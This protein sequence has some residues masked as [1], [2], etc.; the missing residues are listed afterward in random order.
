MLHW[1]A[2]Q[3]IQAAIRAGDLDDLPGAHQPLPPDSLDP[4]VP[5]SLRAAMRVIHNAGGIPVQVLLRRELHEVEKALATRPVDQLEHA[6][7]RERR[8]ELLL[9][10]KQHL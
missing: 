1:I 6:R 8:L 5:S 7:L 9:R 3:R 2:E 4:L 10:L